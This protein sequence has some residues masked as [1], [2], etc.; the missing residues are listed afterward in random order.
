M[1]VVSGAD[2]FGLEGIISDADATALG[3][4]LADKSNK[5]D[6]YGNSLLRYGELATI[7]Q[8]YDSN[9]RQ[10]IITSY[11]AAGG[12]A[13]KL[14]AALDEIDKPLPVIDSPEVALGKE[15]ARKSKSGSL[16][17]QDLATIL[18]Q[19]SAPARGKIIAAY[20]AASGEA[21]TL[22]NALDRLKRNAEAF[23]AGDFTVSKTATTIWGVL[24]T[25]SAAASGY[26]GYRRNN[27]LGWGI[28]WFV[29]GSLFPVIT[30]T[31]ALAQGFGKPRG[32]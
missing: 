32:V 28:G 2:L 14:S 7:L 31:V 29:L 5:T 10:K 20:V 17:W 22:Q 26:H 30:P 25:L 8:Q 9:S 19:Y 23:R 21:T 12:D 18:E 4:A 6:Q 3:K 27:S 13:Y 11:T 24:A 15:L 1:L 16:F